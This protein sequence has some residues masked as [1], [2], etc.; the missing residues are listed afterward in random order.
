MSPSRRSQQALKDYR[1]LSVW[2]RVRDRA[3]RDA[4]LRPLVDPRGELQESLVDM[5]TAFRRLLSVRQAR[6]YALRTAGWRRLSRGMLYVLNCPPF[7]VT[8]RASAR[9]CRVYRWCPCCWAREVVGDVYDRLQWHF[10]GERAAQSAH[11]AAVCVDQLVTGVHSYNVSQT[12]DLSALLGEAAAGLGCFR[13]ELA[14]EG[15]FAL[16]TVEPLAADWVVRHR[17]LA[18]VDPLTELPSMVGLDGRP[19]RLERYSRVARID[20]GR[21]VAEVCRY[22]TQ[23][24]KGSIE[25]TAALLNEIEGRRLSS[26]YGC[27]RNLTARRKR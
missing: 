24:M 23:L 6:A 18:V 2:R 26:N 9:S 8:S 20:L 16:T 10:F 27:L 1:V 12:A 17:F 5:S 3:Q 19:Y 11:D 15:G 13:A 25:A 7:G 4:V 14:L 21:A 22:P